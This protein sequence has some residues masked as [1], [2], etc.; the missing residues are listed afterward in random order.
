MVF[1]VGNGVGRGR[2]KAGGGTTRVLS[3]VPRL[4]LGVSFGGPRSLLQNLFF[5]LPVDRLCCPVFGLVAMTTEVPCPTGMIDMT[6]TII[7]LIISLHL[8]LL[9]IYLRIIVEYTALRHALWYTD[10]CNF[11]PPFTAT[12]INR[13][14]EI[15]MP[16]IYH[17][18]GCGQFFKLKYTSLDNIQRINYLM[19]PS[20]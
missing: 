20:L 10:V 1:F 9:Y 12:C 8:R 14:T 19:D 18:L 11:L 6:Y 2:G 13:G 7:P 16:H 17:L 4:R 3:E 5:E 15:Q